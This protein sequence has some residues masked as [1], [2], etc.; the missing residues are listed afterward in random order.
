V[1][2]EHRNRDLLKGRRKI[3]F[4]LSHGAAHARS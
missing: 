1:S 4:A 2:Y 3:K